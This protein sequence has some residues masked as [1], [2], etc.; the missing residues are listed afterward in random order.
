MNILKMTFLAVTFGFMSFTT[1]S[2]IK[3]KSECIDVGEIA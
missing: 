3:W 1:V 2:N